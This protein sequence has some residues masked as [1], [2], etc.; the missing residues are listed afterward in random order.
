MANYTNSFYSSINN[1]SRI[2]AIEINNELVSNNEINTLNNIDTSRT[3]QDQI[4]SIV[5]SSGATGPVGA[6]GPI[7]PQGPVGPKGSS[8]NDGNDG[9]SLIWKNTYS[10]SLLYYTNDIVYYQGSSYICILNKTSNNSFN[11]CFTLMAQKGDVGDVGPKGD[12]G[13]KGNPGD[14]SLGIIT[15]VIAGAVSGVLANSV[16][17]FFNDIVG[18]LLE[19]FGQNHPAP[20]DEDIFRSQMQGINET[21]NNHEGRIDILEGKTYYMITNTLSSETAFVG[22]SVRIGNQNNNI[23][24]NNGG[25]TANNNITTYNLLTS[26]STYGTNEPRIR[27]LYTGDDID[28]FNETYKNIGG[29]QIGVKRNYSQF[30]INRNLCNFNYRW[31]GDDSPSNFAY[32][33]SPYQ[34]S[35]NGI[36]NENIHMKF[37]S[38]GS[39]EIDNLDINGT[40]RLNNVDITNLPERVNDIEVDVSLLKNKTVNISIT[41]GNTSIGSL[42]IN[43]DG[44]ISVN[45]S[46][47]TTGSLNV[48]GSLA[49]N[50]ITMSGDLFCLGNADITGDVVITGDLTINHDLNVLNNISCTANLSVLQNA[51]VYGNLKVYQN[52]EVNNI[53]CNDIN[54]LGDIYS[55]GDLHVNGTTYLENLRVSGTARINNLDDNDDYSNTLNLVPLFGQLGTY[56]NPYNN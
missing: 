21:L 27:S 48:G 2:N 51:E 10:S 29:L 49:C 46:L 25:L 1:L 9:I 3:I 24:I 56:V 14:A 32:I 28:A 22:C 36:F 43:S 50:S 33:C 47:S 38:H 45:G 55:V 12:K 35:L 20:S 11:T 41:N 23:T 31:Y 5:V 34:N 7:G 30:S 44:S 42:T 17:G 54:A 8:G 18:G 15:G 19:L 40:L 13:D 4:N 53:A 6:T 52:L 26:Y 37:Y 39:T 16:S